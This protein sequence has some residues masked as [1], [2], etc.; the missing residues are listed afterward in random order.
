MGASFGRIL[1][2]LSLLGLIQ[3]NFQAAD[4]LLSEVKLRREIAIQQ[5]ETDL[6]DLLRD[7]E[8]ET[9]RDPKVAREHLNAAQMLLD[10]QNVLPAQKK[11]SWTRKLRLVRADLAKAEGSSVVPARDG[12]QTFTG[13]QPKPETPRGNE[14]TRQSLEELNRLKDQG[15]LDERAARAES[16]AKKDPNSVYLQ[17]A[18]RQARIDGSRANAAKDREEYSRGNLANMNDID[19][20]SAPQA[21]DVVLPPDWAEKS[22]RRS[23]AMQM[24]PKERQVMKALSSPINVDL[25]NRNFQVFLDEMERHLGVPLVV[26]R[27]ALEQV[28]VTSETTLNLRA[29]NWTGRSVMRKVLADLGL[30]YVVR[31]EE[32]MITVPERAKEMMIT[33]A[34]YVGD[35]VTSQNLIGGWPVNQLQMMQTINGI[36]ESIK[37]QV[38]PDSWAPKGGG[39]IFFDPISMSIMVKQTAEVHFQLGSGGK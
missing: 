23:L 19:R 14:Q 6:R 27:G 36:I 17:F 37:S 24:S 29:R 38:D 7:A 28:N 32:V 30:T 9:S 5:L 39:T 25:T 13:R 33:K 31:N 3:Q 22:K 34:Y 2:G 21:V 10:Q 4:D 1:V 12:T 16:L 18:A 26:D 15:K 20:S 35:L 8:K 11:D